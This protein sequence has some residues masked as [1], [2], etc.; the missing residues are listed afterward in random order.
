MLKKLSQQMC[1]NDYIS[2][3]SYQSLMYQ[4]WNRSPDSRPH[5]SQL[6]ETI[7]MMLSQTAGYLDLIDLPPNKLLNEDT[8]EHQ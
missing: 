4:C 8:T 6:V 5:F 3:C 2:S 7:A 1:L